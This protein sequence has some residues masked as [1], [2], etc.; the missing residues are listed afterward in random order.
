[1]QTPAEGPTLV[2]NVLANIFQEMPLGNIAGAMFFLLLFFAA[3]TSTI[4][5]LEAPSAYFMDQKQW[6]RKK[7]AWTVAI[8]AFLLGI[9]SALSTGAIESLSVMN[10][11]FLG[12]IKTGV[13]DIFDYMFGSLLMM[14]V[15]LS[16]C[17]FT[18]WFIKTE[19]LV[20]EIEQ[21]MPS[22]KSGSILGIA[23]YKIWLFMIRFVC[24]IIIGLVILN[25]F[26]VFGE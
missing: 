18:G 9:P 6:P 22:F 15:V 13:M 20:D 11:N 19:I 16:T 21:G 25:M 26:G 24:P 1:M 23:P 2:F 10:V 8:A 17:L 5:M 3:I 14:L 7:A 4:S 12:V